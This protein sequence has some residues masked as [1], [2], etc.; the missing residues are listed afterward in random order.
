V[1]ETGQH[2][3]KV[4]K[5]KRP[6]LEKALLILIIV[7]NCI[8]FGWNCK[9]FH[10]VYGRIAAIFV[11][12]KRG[13]RVLQDRR[14]RL[15]GLGANKQSGNKKKG[16]AENFAHLT[17]QL[18]AVILYQKSSASR[19]KMLQ[20]LRRGG[21]NPRSAAAPGASLHAM[22]KLLSTLFVTRNKKIVC[23]DDET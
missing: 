6:T 7:F 23:D 2:C 5:E 4:S 11:G 9:I 10:G 21:G 15:V 17:E 22:C 18:F 1:H 14:R 16:N 8:I 19:F 12:S 13:C 20:H 3:Y